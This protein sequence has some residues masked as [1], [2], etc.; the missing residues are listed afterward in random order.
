MLDLLEFIKSNL[1]LLSHVLLVEGWELLG[2]KASNKLTRVCFG[3][4]LKFFG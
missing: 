2:K 3:I 4:W 1:L